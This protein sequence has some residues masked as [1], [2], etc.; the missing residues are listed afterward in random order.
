M[1]LILG[2]FLSLSADRMEV[3]T[4]KCTNLI[5]R[6]FIRKKRTE[7]TDSYCSCRFSTFLYLL[8]CT[9]SPHINIRGPE[10]DSE[11]SGLPHKHVW[12]EVQLN[13]TL[14]SWFI[15]SKHSVH[16]LFS[17]SCLSFVFS[18]W[19]FCCLHWPLSRVWKGCLVFL[20]TGDYDVPY[21]E[22]VSVG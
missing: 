2:N 18:F 4:T 14:L 22:N 9:C 6:S 13:S 19:W 12:G 11:Q 10:Q 15:L 5:C 21:R 7:R 20:S 8:N 3:S 1:V 16:G 17:A